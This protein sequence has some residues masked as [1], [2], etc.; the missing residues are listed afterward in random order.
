MRVLVAS[1][2]YILVVNSIGVAMF[3]AELSQCT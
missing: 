3:P 1:V 2:V